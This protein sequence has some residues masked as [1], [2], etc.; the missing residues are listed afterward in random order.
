MLLTMTP[1]AHAPLLEEWLA[2]RTAPSMPP[3]QE[4]SVASETGPRSDQRETL[5]KRLAQIQQYLTSY[6]TRGVLEVPLRTATMSETL[7]QL[8]EYVLQCIERVVV[9]AEPRPVPPEG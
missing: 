3:V 5:Y 2:L 9:Q 4:S 8:H 1:S 7:D 6:C